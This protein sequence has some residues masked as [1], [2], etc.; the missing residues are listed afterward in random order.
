MFIM[1]TDG[2]AVLYDARNGAYWASSTVGSN[3]RFIFQADG[4]LVIY[5]GQNRALWSPQTEGKGGISLQMQNDGNLVLYRADATPVWATHT[6][7]LKPYPS[8]PSALEI[9]KDLRGQALVSSN[10]LFTFVMQTDGNA[11]LYD[12]TR[13]GASYWASSTVGSNRRFIFQTDGNLVIYEGNTPVWNTRTD[14]KG[15]VRL[16]MQN[17][18]NLVLYC[19][20]NTYV[21]ATH[22]VRC[23]L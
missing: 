1:Q 17:D 15:G 23:L 18:G 2:N 10:C 8:G 11:V 21:W 7:R 20:D 16:D 3:R 14:G 5:D 19:A 13:D 12:A 4:N 22:T 9:G 6:V